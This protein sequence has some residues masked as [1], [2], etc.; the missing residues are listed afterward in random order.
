MAPDYHELTAL[1]AADAMRAGR[2]TPGDYIGGLI[3]RIEAREPDI[4]AWQHF[5]P[6][7]AFAQTASLGGRAGL[8]NLPLAGTAAGIKDIIDTADMPSENGTV[9]DKG[10]QPSAD[11]AVVRL[12]REAGVIIMG[13]TVT[14]ELAFMHPS[15]TR[16]PHN[17][18]HTPGGSS[19]G[20][21]AAVAAGMVPIALG[22]QTNGS[23]VRPASFCGI[24]GFKPTFGLVP[25]EGV[26]E[27]S[28]SL[29][30]VGVFARS[31]TDIAAV[32]QVLATG[33]EPTAT[34]KTDDQKTTAPKTSHIPALDL[35]DAAVKRLIKAAK[36]RGYVTYDEL[37]EVLPPDG[38]SPGQIE[39]IMAMFS[40]LGVNVVDA[41]QVPAPNYIRAARDSVSERR[42]A[43]VRTPAWRFAEEGAKAAI[44][45]FA[46]GLGAS[47]ER[48]D[49][50][51]EFDRAIAMH[52]T[53]ML[54]EIALNFG[55]YYDRGKDRLSTAMR[56]AI[57]AGRGLLAVHYAEAL[58]ERE[59]LYERFENL[60]RPYD[61]VITLP[62]AGPAPRGH[63][64]TG[65]PAFCTIWTYLGVPALNLPLLTVE[66]LP[67]G[68]QL[69]GPRL[70]EA[71]LFQAAAALLSRA[72][73]L[74]KR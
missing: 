53:V 23:V 61:S 33:L 70:G 60:L 66:G 48:L 4:Q 54:A 58:R 42:F 6:K 11:A 57:E 45:T 51:P 22:T 26:L 63:D 1:D 21:A 9:L 31:L 39:D 18:E 28:G 3:A 56:E 38:V 65:N 59:R 73:S 15:K 20:S 49:L 47:C 74:P 64:T 40:D 69:I 14:T 12:L 44:E 5:D 41:G 50:P 72:A 62:A 37:N 27:E 13:K 43:F 34:T 16:N 67:L 19:S 30:T 7:Q 25:R 46:E 29:D 36:S 35:L 52:R 68:V 8:A 24:Y 2:M 17:V 71:K 55:H 10:R 32:T